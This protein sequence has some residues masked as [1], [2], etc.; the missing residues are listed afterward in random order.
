M[1]NLCLICTLMLCLT[2]FPAKLHA[3]TQPASAPAS[4]TATPAPAANPK[5]PEEFFARARQLSDLEAA[6]I[7]FHLKATYVAAGDA[8]FTGDGT[9]EEWWQSNDAW[10][11]EATLGDYKYVAFPNQSYCASDYV[12]LRLSQA[13]D[14]F[15]IKIP[16]NIGTTYKWKF[17][18]KKLKNMGNLIGLTTE[19]DCGQISSKEQAKC[20]MQDYFTREGLLRIRQSLGIATVYNGIQNFN[21]LLIPRSITA[22]AAGPI[23]ILNISITTL[24][25]LSA[26]EKTATSLAAIPAGLQPYWFIRYE[27]KQHKSATPPHII[28]QAAPTYPVEAREKGMSGAVVIDATID[29]QGNVREPYVILS[30]GKPLDA[31]AL[32]AVRQWKYTPVTVDGKP[33]AIETTIA[34][35]FSLRSNNS[36]IFIDR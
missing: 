34:V 19:Y 2:L 12:P 13:I 18:R 8:E 9:I 7:P 28:Q 16:S 29:D 32:T 25:P 36:V 14:M 30:A 15:A 21:G 31:S 1:T 24:E 33:I 10:R 35:I 27:A 17:Q 4:S 23:Q 5:T 3:Q 26:D 11:L 6:G 20:E 22:I